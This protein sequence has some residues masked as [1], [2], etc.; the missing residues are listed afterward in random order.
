MRKSATATAT[1]RRRLAAITL[2]FVALVAIG[3]WA[4]ASPVGSSPDDDFH[5]NSAWCGLGDRDGLC[6]EASEEGVKRAPIVTDASAACF[7]FAPE[8]SAECQDLGSAGQELE[9]RPTDRG[10]FVSQYPGVYYGFAGVFASTDV[11]FSAVIMRTANALIFVGMV[12]AVFV[13]LPARYRPA[14]LWPAILTLVPLG[15]FLV[16]SNNP[17]S[18][19][20]TSAVTTWIAYL[21]YLQ[22]RGRRQIVLGGLAFLGA[23]LGAGARSDSAAYTVLALMLTT[24]VV[25][26]TNRRFAI[27]SIF[28]AVIVAV[29][30]VLNIGSRSAGV[31]TSGFGGAENGPIDTFALVASNLLNMPYLWGG[32]F[33]M[34]GLGWLDTEMPAIVWFATLC[35]F[36]AVTFFA[37]REATRQQKLA[38]VVLV[39]AL[40][41]IPSYVLLL[42]G[43]GVGAQVQ[44]RYLLPLIIIFAGFATLRYA[45]SGVTLT[46]A[47]GFVIGLCIAGANLVALHFNLRRYVTG[48]D[49]QSGNLDAQIEWWWA[50]MPIGPMS[51]WLIG[52]VSFAIAVFLAIYL[53]RLPEASK[54]SLER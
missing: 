53:A 8:Q 15:L 27:K 31:A 48:T 3:A 41:L 32:V 40:W 38:L 21:G 10:N 34:W 17:S 6:E 47:Q 51:L 4:F 25:G 54:D 45:R 49:V 44:P 5:L 29:V 9:L 43:A 35:A 23:I 13:A 18:W 39:A 37:V 11:A 19:A 22:T 7:A 20:V 52:S 50:G 16:S 33:G 26:E 46:R 12:T 14:L 42:S 28:G 1:T 30:V 24:L 2:P 36:V